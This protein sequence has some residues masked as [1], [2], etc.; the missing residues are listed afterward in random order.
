MSLARRTFHATRWATALNGGNQLGRVLLQ[1]LLAGILGPDVFGLA[2]RLMAVGLI[3]DQAAEFGF[4]AALIQRKRLGAGH[5]VGAFH[6]NLGLGLVLALAGLAAIWIHAAVA[7]W[8]EFTHLLQFVM[9]VPLVMALGHVQR[10]LLTRALDF[11]LQTWANLGGNG[12]NVVVAVGLALADRGVWSILAGFY[13]NHATQAGVMWLGSDWRP[14]GWPRWRAIRDLLAFGVYVAV[15]R[16]FRALTRG[17]DVLLIGAL[18]GDGPA[19]LF[20]V[21]LRIGVLAINQIGAVLNSVLFASFS[22]LQDDPPRMRAAFLRALRLLSVSSVVPVIGAFALAPL[23]P[24]VLGEGWDEVAP[25]ARVLC[26]AVVWQGLGGVLVPVVLRGAGRPGLELLRTGVMVVTLPLFVLVGVPHGL[27]GVCV[28]LAGYWA[29]QM[30][31]AQVLVARTVGTSLTQYL[32]RVWDVV[33]AFVLATL[34]ALAVEWALPGAGARGRIVDAALALPASLLVYGAV[35][36][37][38]DRR[39]IPEVVRAVGQVAR[40]KGE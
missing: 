26:F 21:G 8:S 20:S 12:A 22:R 29:I 4:N 35:I 17:I 36:H 28:A 13:A 16:L 18:L 6:M 2:A 5:R 7:G 30:T 27:L 33:L 14:R 39:A 1:F 11:R 31:L 34:A 23:V 10:A 19:G 9:P 3:L 32:A 24:V 38:L 37:L 25:V 15:A 40:A